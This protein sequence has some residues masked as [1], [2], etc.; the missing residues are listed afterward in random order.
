MPS[1]ACHLPSTTTAVV[2]F[3]A[4]VVPALFARPIPTAHLAPSTAEIVPSPIPAEARPS[5]P[6]PLIGFAARL[7]LL[8]V[9]DADLL[10]G[11]DLLLLDAGH[12]LVRA[13]VDEV[14]RHDVGTHAFVRPPGVDQEGV[15]CVLRR[16]LT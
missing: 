6:V 2:L 5:P 13:Q 14:L 1:A 7:D 4:A 9:L 11:L 15:V 12:P 16:A 8:L 10:D 3:S